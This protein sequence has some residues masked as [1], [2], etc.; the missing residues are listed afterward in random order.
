[1]GD[2]AGLHEPL[3]APTDGGGPGA[4]AGAGAVTVGAGLQVLAVPGAGE[5]GAEGALVVLAAT[6]AIA[7]RLASAAVGSRLSV[8]LLAP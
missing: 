6:P 5:D 4:A 8:T 1:M 3:A 7:A 2:E